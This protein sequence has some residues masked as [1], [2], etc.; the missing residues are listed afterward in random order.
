MS[1]NLMQKLDIYLSEE[2]CHQIELDALSFEIFK[3]NGQINRNKLLRM[4][5]DGYYDEYDTSVKRKRNTVESCLL[6]VNLSEGN[7]QEL[8]DDIMR[9]V[10]LTQIP[11]GRTYK[12]QKISL[13]PSKDMSTIMKRIKSNVISPDS[14]SMYLNRMISSYCSL[15]FYH[16]EQILF[17][18]NYILLKDCCK[19]ETPI[20]FGT[21]WDPE[22][23][24]EVIPYRVI[25]GKEE[26]YNYLLCAENN[27]KTGKQETKAYR[28]NRIINI[29]QV[30]VDYIIEDKV[31]TH[32]DEM[33]HMHIQYVINDDEEICVKLN[34]KGV[35]S[36]RNIFFGRPDVHRIEKKNGCFYY[37]F[38]GSSEQ[39]FFYFRR[40][41][42]SAEVISPLSL[43]KRFE[44]F[45]AE[46]ADIYRNND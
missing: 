29:K 37:Y 22:S 20:I 40:F 15:P 35:R 36:F 16:R 18:D 9:N 3:K 34:D 12:S 23:I 11:S 19:T 28:L 14:L 25:T 39:V 13:K 33:V 41:G 32:L 30:A 26:L 4:L 2:T 8:T 5:I 17:K 45:H 10:V 31:R 27:S 24:H 7:I 38:L 43:R 6:K 1:S 42:K 46:T 21:T 44:I